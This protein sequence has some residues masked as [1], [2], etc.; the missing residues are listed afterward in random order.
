MIGEARRPD[1]GVSKYEGSM[2]TRARKFLIASLLSELH[3]QR[4]VVRYPQKISLRD[5]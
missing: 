2:L 1:D 4:V 5:T 3:P